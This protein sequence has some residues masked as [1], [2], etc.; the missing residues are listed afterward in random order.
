MGGLLS[1]NSFL[2]GAAVFGLTLAAVGPA[3]ATVRTA[4]YAWTPATGPVAGYAVYASVD[5]GDEFFYSYVDAPSV[6]LE[7]DSGAWLVVT[8]AAFDSAGSLGPP[9]ERSPG[10]RLCPGDWDAD[11]F[12][13]MTDL[14]R[15][16]SCFGLLALDQCAGADMNDD[17]VVGIA[18]FGAFKLGADAC[19]GFP[20]PPAPDFSTA[21][22]PTTT[23]DPTPT[24]GPLPTPIPGPDVPP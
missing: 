7:V 13:G 24:P 2:L 14:G 22:D 9:S 12:L 17:G 11:E 15:E 21:P 1:R 5:G 16:R 4:T 8:V 10:L 20:P 19:A 18:D 6:M 23:P 3:E